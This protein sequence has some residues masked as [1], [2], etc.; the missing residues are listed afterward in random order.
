[1]D[2]SAIFVQYIFAILNGLQVS[3]IYIWWYWHWC[4]C[5]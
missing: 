3:E 4:R 5:L 2:A 1:M